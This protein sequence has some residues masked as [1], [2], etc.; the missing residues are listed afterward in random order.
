MQVELYRYVIISIRPSSAFPIKSDIQFKTWAI[1]HSSNALNIIL[2]PYSS[3]W[4]ITICTTAVHYIGGRF[5]S[6]QIIILRNGLRLVF[7]LWVHNEWCSAIYVKITKK[8]CV[9]ILLLKWIDIEQ[10]NKLK[11]NILLQTNTITI[12]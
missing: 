3:E 8:N 6:T 11:R 12:V 2:L 1:F 4:S 7:L 9:C 10:R 5:I